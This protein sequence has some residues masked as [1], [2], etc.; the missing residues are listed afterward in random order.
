VGGGGQKGPRGPTL[1]YGQS[2]GIYMCGASGPF[3]PFV[4]ADDIA[5]SFV[6]PFNCLAPRRFT[7]SPLSFAHYTLYISHYIS[8]TLSL[9]DLIYSICGMIVNF[10]K[11]KLQ[12][13]TVYI[14][15]YIIRQ[16]R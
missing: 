2:I 6:R 8:L 11:S 1:S 3:P 7:F 4:L 5:A 13:G 15:V 9:G 10:C 16:R 12:Y 14:H